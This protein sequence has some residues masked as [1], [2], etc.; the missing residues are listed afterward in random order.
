MDRETA[1]PQVESIPG[2]VASEWVEYHHENSAPSTYVY[3]FV[4]DI[5]ADAEGPFCTDPDGNILLD[6]TS[7]VATAPLGYNN[8][9]IMDRL[10]EF[11]IVDPLKIAG[12]DFYVSTGRTPDIA[13]LPGPAHLM[14]RLT[15]ISEEY[16]MDTVF[17]SNTGAEAIE[18]ALKIC[19]NHCDTPKYG[20]TFEGA[21]H[22]RTLGTL[23]LNR[24]KPVHR[25]KF[26]E[27]SGIQEVPFSTPGVDHL[28]EKLHPENGFLSAEEVAYLIMEPVQ[29][30]GGYNFPTQNFMR[31]VNDLC[32]EYNIPIIAD[33][34]QNGVGRTGKMWASDHFNFEP[35]VISAAK[36]LRVGATVSR[37]NIFPKEKGRLSSTWGAGDILSSIQ[38]ALTLRVIEE[39]D[40][41]ANAQYMGKQFLARLTDLQERHDVL[42]DARGL[43]LLTAVEFDTR[44]NRDDAME[45]AF[46]NGFLTLGC[47]HKSL[48]LLPPLDVTEREL[49]L[50]V[51]ALDEA[52]ETIK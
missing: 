10:R 30:E 41:L 8:P 14:D 4:W 16:D 38:G 21:F 15:D 20:I 13:P 34:I 46:K 2:P 29:G 22:G 49:E 27:I 24:S 25:R 52:V 45:V 40:L 37:A 5:T 1:E 18:N 12:Q 39:D 23:S 31:K 36:G 3:D 9:K 7:Q 17:L 11:D 50:G 35:D 42:V 33:E 44:N 6:F 28:R 51:R 48:R 43:G 47:G 26:P 19:Y 32:E